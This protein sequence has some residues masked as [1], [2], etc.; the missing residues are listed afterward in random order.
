[1]VTMRGRGRGWRGRSSDEWQGC[2]REA[3]LNYKGENVFSL[4][5]CDDES[6]VSAENSNDSFD[7]EI[8]N[9]YG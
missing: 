6:N 4:R 8:S 3:R 9:A 1:M 2:R 7:W 5:M